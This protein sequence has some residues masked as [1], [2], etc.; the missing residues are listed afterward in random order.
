MGLKAQNEIS[1]LYYTYPHCLHVNAVVLGNGM[2]SFTFLGPSP[3]S[4]LFVPY[5]FITHEVKVS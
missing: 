4:F 5:L 3:K 1:M 2:D